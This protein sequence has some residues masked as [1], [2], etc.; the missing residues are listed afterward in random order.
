MHVLKLTLAKIIF[1]QNFLQFLCFNVKRPDCLSSCVQTGATQT[2]GQSGDTSGRARPC[3]MLMW[4]R[5]SGQISDAS[6]QGPHRVKYRISDL[7]AASPH[8]FLNFSCHFGELS[9]GFSH[10]LSLF[11]PFVLLYLISRTMFA[12]SPQRRVHQR[13]EEDV[14]AS[15]AKI[16]NRPIIPKRN[17]FRADIMVAP[18]DDIHQIIQTYH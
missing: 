2:A 16:M 18:L 9:R 17:V 11:C 3:H 1:L 15:K 6:G 14:A 7:A 5:V 8:L 12:G 13:I 4:Q 10:N